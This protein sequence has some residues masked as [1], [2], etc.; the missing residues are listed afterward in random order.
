ML[1]TKRLL[2]I[3]PGSHC[4][5]ALLVEEMLGRVSVLRHEIVERHEGGLLTE[6]EITRHAR[7]VLQELG[8]E[9]V[10]LA[11]PH[12]RALSQVADLP[13]SGNTEI[14]RL[15]E[16]ET[17][18]LSGLGDSNIVFDYVGLGVFG[19]HENPFWLTLCREGEV[20][21]QIER[22]G[23]SHAD[24][25]EVTT[26]A[27]ALIAAWQAIHPERDQAVLVDFGAAGTGVTIL[28]EGQ[29][30]YTTTFPMG[31]DALTE[32][33]ATQQGCSF[34]AAEALKRACDVA[35]RPPELGALTAGLDRWLEELRG[36]LSEWAREHPE[37]DPSANAH[38]VV[39]AGG[40]ARQ[41]GLVDYL[42]R[43]GPLRFQPWPERADE[44]W[45]GDRFAVAY[46]TALQ[47]L[48]RSRQPAS[49]LPAEVRG[50]WRKQH[51]LHL[52]HSLTFFVLALVALVLAF[53]TWQK[54]E[55]YFDKRSLLADSKT[56]LEK[57]RLT[58]DLSRRL[59]HSY[60]RLR[61]VLER[62]EQTLNTLQTLALLQQVRSNQA[63]WY[64]LFADQKSYYT[65]PL[66]GATNAPPPTNAPAI[67][68]ALSAAPTNPPSLKD[69]FV[70]E[71]CVPEEGDA[72][73]RTLSRVVAELKRS[74]L[75]K[76]VDS[77]APDRRRAVADTN[78]VLPDRH[79]ALELELAENPFRLGERGSGERRP[80]GAE[81]RSPIRAA[82]KPPER[83]ASGSPSPT[84]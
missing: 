40:A 64:V 22:C 8:E 3:D 58:D 76:N 75:F 44:D 54:L 24:L 83:P 12:Y 1:P 49:L 23:L 55:E 20:Q 14:R 52:L 18:K 72:Q 63:F 81:T 7:I 2:A 38:T 31:G 45:S 9:P 68:P 82:V 28:I 21:R 69:G 67:P 42:N 5:K 60:D 53:G 62:R 19:K 6:E 11:L 84:P 66:W 65:A 16:E 36:V 78:V 4:L 15:V 74:P 39:L 37:L 27:N 47:A 57:A 35:A 79:F 80:S 10:A 30:V 73:R 25:C 33:V 43:Q 29:A 13:A 51:S 71:L 59:A 26:T 46:G 50:Y 32:A 56:A 41:P 34:E 61:P 48:G 77:L 70:A 17:V